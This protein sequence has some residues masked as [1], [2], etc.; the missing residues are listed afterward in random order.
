MA[1]FINRQQ[2]AQTST[3]SGYN[4]KGSLPVIYYYWIDH[5]SSSVLKQRHLLAKCSWACEGH[6]KAER[7]PDICQFSTQ[8]DAS[9]VTYWSKSPWRVEQLGNIIEWLR[10]G[11]NVN[12]HLD[13]EVLSRWHFKNE[14]G[15]VLVAMVIFPPQLHFFFLF[16]SPLSGLYFFQDWKVQC[17]ICSLGPCFG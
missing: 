1:K 11:C 13:E 16:F 2:R 6:F 12:D 10:G 14:I 17:Q 5:T 3:D 9:R 8:I 15:C 7:T 4:L